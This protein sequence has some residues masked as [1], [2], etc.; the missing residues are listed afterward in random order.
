MVIQ[1][2]QT[3]MLLI[4]VILMAIF[5]LTP[6]GIQAAEPENVAIFVKDA[7]VFLVLNLVI[8][9]LLVITIFMYKDLRRQKRMTILSMVLI[10]VSIVTGLFILGRAYDSASPV[11]LGG[12]SLLVLALIFGLLAYRGMSRDHKLL[13]SADRLR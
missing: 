8:A 9:A 11:L 4:A 12:V 13:R 10:C 1:R 3:L 7:P 2:I 6:Y 5:C